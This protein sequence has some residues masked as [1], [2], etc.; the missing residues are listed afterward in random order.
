VNQA[1]AAT[2]VAGQNGEPQQVSAGADADAAARMAEISQH[3]TAAP[4]ASTAGPKTWG[5]ATDQ[6]AIGPILQQPLGFLPRPA[7]L[8]QLDQTRRHGPVVQVVTGM[9]GTGK[10][11]LAAAYARAKLAGGWRLVV[12]VNASTSGNL[13]AGLAAAADAAGLSD[14]GSG[15]DAAEAGHAVRQL[16]EG[17]GERCLLVFDD[18]EDHDL[19]RP[20]IPVGGAAQVLVLAGRQPVVNLGSEIRV[21]AFTEEE[22]LAFL[23]GRTGLGEAGAKSV[24]AAVGYLPLAMAQVGAV[25]AGE[26][27]GYESCLDQLNAL[28]VEERLSPEDEQSYPRGVAESVMLSLNAVQASDQ[29][30][31]SSRVMTIMAV[32]SAAG[33]RREL[34][35]V[36]GQMG[37]LGACGP[38]DPATVDRALER[39]A[40][41]SL[42]NFSLNRQTVVVHRLARQVIWEALTR[43][44]RL[45]FV[46]RVATSVLETH[47]D[48][49]AG[50]RNCLVVR[51]IAEQVAA[52]IENAAWLADATDQELV[53]TLLRVGFFGLSHLI[54]LGDRAQAV[55]LGTQLTVGLEQMLGR[56]DPHTLDARETL[57]AAY[58]SAGNSVV[59]SAM[60]ELALAARER[61]LGPDHPDT[62]RSRQ[63][64]A[65]VY[66]SAGEVARAVPLVEQILDARERLLGADH[67][68]TLQ[69]RN[70]LAAAYLEASRTAEAIPLFEQV[71]AA[72]ERL[73][74]ANDSRTQAAR[75]NFAAANQKAGPVPPS[76]PPPGLADHVGSDL[77]DDGP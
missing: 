3:A 6:L 27:L 42:V 13:L 1:N 9:R 41:R 45:A 20:F 8:A 61:V 14:G 12:W 53:D 30:G 68:A 64:L 7:L 57:A 22:A 32:L 71:L 17:D 49:L 4:A 73:L 38:V 58:Q 2:G 15:W 16:L 77:Q 72:C 35:Y 39:L 59:A 69:A 65:G 56:D 55:A 10:T 62:M 25:I 19:V 36:A 34:L 37:A 33:V 75:H 66:R 67:P 76:S 43:Q 29:T 24:A 47:A 21:D 26:Y 50:S 23:D 70:N 46:C 74:G 5:T 44:G 48:A 18:V 40:E 28:S 63:R 60:F 31:V 51:H 52:V 54:E 11:Q